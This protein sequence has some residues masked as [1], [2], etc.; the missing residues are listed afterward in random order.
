MRILSAFTS[1]HALNWLIY[2]DIFAGLFQLVPIHLIYCVS[3]I[4][5]QRIYQTTTKTVEHQRAL[6]SF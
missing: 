4:G 6:E 5:L 1:N 3:G 2:D